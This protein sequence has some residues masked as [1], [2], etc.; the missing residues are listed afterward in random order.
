[1]TRH[2]GDFGIEHHCRSNEKGEVE[3]FEGH[4]CSIDAN[5]GPLKAA[6]LAYKGSQW[7]VRVTWEK[8]WYIVWEITCTMQHIFMG[9]SPKIENDRE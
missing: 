4:L 8:M 3:D 7:N 2:R 1:M 9:V 5:Q 6:D